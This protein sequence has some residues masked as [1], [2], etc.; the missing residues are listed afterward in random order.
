MKIRLDKFLWS[1]RL[2]KTRSAATQMVVKGHV[3]LNGENIKPAREIKTEQIITI[4]RH[5][6]KFQYKIL[7][8]LERRVGATLVKDYILDITPEE[9]VEKFR[10]Y[11]SAQKAYHQPDGKPSKKDRRNL[12][13]FMDNW[14]GD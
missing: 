8:L 14:G 11:Q 10:Q 9:E 13:R 12:D 1:V 7:A 6:A 4:V 2:S 3:L 5:N